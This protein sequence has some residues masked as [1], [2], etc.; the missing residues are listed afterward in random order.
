MHNE[1]KAAADLMV[2]PLCLYQPCHCV[3]SGVDG[4]GDAATA[5]GVAQEDGVGESLQNPPI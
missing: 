5:D 4:V 1:R 2:D 3:I